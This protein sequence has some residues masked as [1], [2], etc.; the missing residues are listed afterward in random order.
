MN[1]D[2]SKIIFWAELKISFDA[3]KN[4]VIKKN[5]K[6]IFL[7]NR[8]IEIKSKTKTTGIKKRILV[9]NKEPKKI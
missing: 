6:T 7:L 2:N 3:P 5:D 4:R 1:T 8:F 9:W